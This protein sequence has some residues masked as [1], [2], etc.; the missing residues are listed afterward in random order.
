MIEHSPFKWRYISVDHQKAGKV[1]YAMR[2]QSDLLPGEIHLVFLV[3]A[4]DN[5][6]SPTPMKM[7]IAIPTVTKSS[8]SVFSILVFLLKNLPHVSVLH[9]DLHNAYGKILLSER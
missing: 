5:V 9:P 1:S 7:E 6:K 3:T 4:M 2:G 8:N